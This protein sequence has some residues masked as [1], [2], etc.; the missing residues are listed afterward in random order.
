MKHLMRLAMVSGVL[1]M[2]WPVAALASTTGGRDCDT[3]ALV[4]CGGYTTT[5]LEGKIASG[6]GVNSAANLQ[7]IYNGKGMTTAAINSTVDGTVAQDGRV[8]VNGKV[9]ATNA[10][11][12]GPPQKV[13]FN[14]RR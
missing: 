4:Y 12:D 3:N 14:G 6:D 7:S 11:S 9:V 5:E 1:A 13:R 8:F 10:K 2:A